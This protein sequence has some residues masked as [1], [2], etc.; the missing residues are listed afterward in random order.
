MFR[1]IEQGLNAV[2]DRYGERCFRGKSVVHT[3]KDCVCLVHEHLC[4]VSV[5]SCITQ[6]EP[7]AMEIDHDWELMVRVELEQSVIVGR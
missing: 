2:V 1:K 7:A 5:I 4:P 3:D 6:A